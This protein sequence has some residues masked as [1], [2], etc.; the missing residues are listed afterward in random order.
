[1]EK[2]KYILCVLLLG[3][4]GMTAGHWAGCAGESPT[5]PVRVLVLKSAKNLEL[6]VPGTFSLID[7]EHSKVL[8]EKAPALKSKV[9][10]T[11]KGIW[12]NGREYPTRRLAIEPDRDTAIAINNR[13]FRGHVT[14]MAS[15]GLLDVINVVDLEQYIKGVLYHEVSHRWPLEAIKAQA[16]A[17]RSYAV[18][19]MQQK[20][21]KDFDVTNDI[22][23]QVYGGKN[24]ER[25]RT[26]LA[27]DGTKGQVLVYQRKVLPAFF[28]A[29][30]AGITEDA[31]EVWNVKLPPLKSMDCPYCQ[32]SPHMRW[33]RN[34]RLKDI[35]AKLNAAGH[36]IGL[37]KD[38]VIVERNASDRIKTLKITGRAGESIRIPGKDFRNIIGPNDIRSNNYEVVMK[39][40][41][42]DFYGRGWGHGV[43]LCQWGA[44][45]MAQ[46]QFDFKAI[47][48]HYYPRAELTD[49][50][51]L[52]LKL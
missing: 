37:I 1:M 21:G 13:R 28:H 19:S 15:K 16:V 25:F 14:I 36:K 50:D 49:L 10:A 45:G 24:S 17:T 39:G 34:F 11:S 3:G 44:Y 8:E 20:E 47:L 23:S 12:I 35:Q 7:E 38:I 30:C 41:Y 9:Y 40:W 51:K 4:A 2:I 22:Y 32:S 33:K 31:S 26:N 52:N 42:V 27:V 6:T 48:N 43:G 5:R 46:Q 18:Y 29:T